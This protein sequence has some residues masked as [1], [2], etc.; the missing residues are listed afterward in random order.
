MKRYMKRYDEYQKINEDLSP[1]FY[2]YGYYDMANGQPH[3]VIEYMKANNIS[4]TYDAYSNYIEV[5]TFDTKELV[6]K[7]EQCDITKIDWKDIDGIID[8]ENPGDCLLLR[9][10][11]PVIP[12]GAYM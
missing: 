9:R 6:S 8:S 7:M 2:D 1:N 5:E 3:D 11:S 10:P 4:Y 12:N